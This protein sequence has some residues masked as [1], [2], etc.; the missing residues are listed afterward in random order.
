MYTDSLRILKEINI[1]FLG[2]NNYI[3]FYM[4]NFLTFF[5]LLALLPVLAVYGSYVGEGRLIGREADLSDVI[6]SN[7]FSRE[8]INTGL[9]EIE[10]LL[11]NDIPKTS[12]SLQSESTANYRKYKEKLWSF[13]CN[14]VLYTG[15]CLTFLLFLFGVLYLR[16]WNH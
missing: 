4:N 14:I 12:G 16:Y 8:N 6:I 7:P 5:C 2:C 3:K 9:G 15:I 10:Y 1:E 11:E 13:R